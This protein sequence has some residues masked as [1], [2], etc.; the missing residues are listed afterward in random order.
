MANRDAHFLGSVTDIQFSIHPKGVG[1]KL[2]KTSF[3][4]VPANPVKTQSAAYMAGDEQYGKGYDAIFGEGK[5]ARSALPSP[6]A[7]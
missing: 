6:S 4:A 2:K 7:N 5:K 1:L 3:F